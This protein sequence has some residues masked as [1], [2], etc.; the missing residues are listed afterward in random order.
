MTY[1]NV[2]ADILESHDTPSEL[3]NLIS[4]LRKDEI[5][6]LTSLNELTVNLTEHGH[7]NHVRHALFANSLFK[8][9]K[10]SENDD[11]AEKAAIT[12][13][14]TVEA[15]NLVTAERLDLFYDKVMTDPTYQSTTKTIFI[16]WRS[17]LEKFFKPFNFDDVVPRVSTGAT[18]SHKRGKPVHDK[19]AFPID[20]TEQLF[21]HLTDRYIHSERKEDMPSL[22]DKGV[23][24]PSKYNIVTGARLLVVPKTYQIGRVICKE[25]TANI[26]LQCGIGDWIRNRLKSY[27]NLDIR[28]AQEEHKV[29]ALIG[30][31]DNSI[32]TIDLSSASDSVTRSLVSK[33][34][35]DFYLAVNP[36]VSE[37][38]MVP[39][40]PKFPYEYKHELALWLTSGN[41][42]CFEFETV[43]FHTLIRAC[44]AFCDN[45]V[46]G[47][48]MI[49]T[50][51]HDLQNLLKA[52]VFF[53]FTPN[54]DKTFIDG[55]FR[56]SCGA[57]CYEGHN[58]RGTYVKREIGAWID[59]IRLANGI[60]RCYYYNNNNVWV[61]SY[62][63]RIWLRICRHIPRDYRLFGPKYLG[64]TCI[65]TEN[66]SCYKTRTDRN[67]EGFKSKQG[68]RYNKVTEILVYGFSI[69]KDAYKPLYETNDKGEYTE[70]AV[71]TFGQRLP[72]SLLLSAVDYGLN[73]QFELRTHYDKYG[74]VIRSED[75]SVELLSNKSHLVHDGSHPVVISDA[76]HAYNRTWVVYRQYPD[77]FRGT[78]LE[79][80]FREVDQI[81]WRKGKVTNLS[82]APTVRKLSYERRQKQEI[83]RLLSVLSKHKDNLVLWEN[84]QQIQP[85]V[86]KTFDA[87]DF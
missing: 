52:L 3:Q 41:G 12:K 57:D 70:H 32:S 18:L 85:D 72:G 60:R 45:Y 23:Y 86:S 31:D 19:M 58:V 21:Y 28:S 4:A 30:S 87:L 75:G 11:S 10:P 25:P 55:A 83:S 63:R 65:N 43:L 84:Q 68:S 54:E 46:Y 20:I 8:K 38:I 1:K 15:N 59:W 56:E 22:I 42:F 2:L 36:V 6:V 66:T 26:M 14:F 77:L 49:V 17:E 44:G 51:N 73:T 40:G 35:R 61:S 82:V 69:P 50:N 34:C 33:L 81:L 13:F 62:F 37:E 64:D 24:H 80:F 7:L 16:K 78:D 47:D 5:S 79:S 74:N 67:P 76:S 71:T 29:L 53:G 48:D 39:Y 27:Y 9:L